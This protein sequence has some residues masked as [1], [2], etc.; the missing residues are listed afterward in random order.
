MIEFFEQNYKKWWF[1]VLLPL[2]I[3][4][5]VLYFMPQILV[6]R[7]KD[8]IEKAEKFDEMIKK[9]REEIEKKKQEAN[10]KATSYEAKAEVYEEMQ[11]ELEKNRKNDVDNNGD[12]H[13]DENF[14][15]SLKEGIDD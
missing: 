14:T 11:K 12:W 13:T 1:W 9:D 5:A 8:D 2:I 7:I 4:G 15:E 3:I 6:G 10:D